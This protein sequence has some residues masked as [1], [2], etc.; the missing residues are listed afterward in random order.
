MNS[1]ARGQLQMRDVSVTVAATTSAL[2]F[3]DRFRATDPFLFHKSAPVVEFLDIIWNKESVDSC[4]GL[5]IHRY[6]SPDST[7]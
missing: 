5:M 4:V 2:A 7:E 1:D 6:L 3:L